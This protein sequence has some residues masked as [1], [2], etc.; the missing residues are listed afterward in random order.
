MRQFLLWV[1]L[2]VAS[3]HGALAQQAHG[4]LKLGHVWPVN[5]EDRYLDCVLVDSD[6]A[7]AFTRSI[8]VL[9]RGTVSAKTFTGKLEQHELEE[10]NSILANPDLVALDNAP[11]SALIGGRNIFDLEYLRVGIV[12]PTAMQVL[13]FDT[14][15][16]S[17]RSPALTQPPPLNLYSIG[18]NN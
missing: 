9:G 14:G 11:K 7:F 17:H 15:L 18:T 12:R 13:V 6:G 1:F 3:V 2:V 8:S 4:L 16:S 10:L 5:R